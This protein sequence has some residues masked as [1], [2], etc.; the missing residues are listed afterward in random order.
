MSNVKDQVLPAQYGFSCHAACSGLVS[1]ICI[2]RWY[3]LHLLVCTT[4]A[5]YMYTQ[6]LRKIRS[7]QA[8]LVVTLEVPHP[9]D[10]RN[11][12][13]APPCCPGCLVAAASCAASLL[14]CCA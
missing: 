1:H 6:G 4:L 7:Q 13:G 11:N 9:S 5:V 8:N 14:P 12:L 10:G 3:A 2:H